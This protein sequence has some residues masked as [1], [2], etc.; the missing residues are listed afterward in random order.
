M[1]AAVKETDQAKLKITHTAMDFTLWGGSKLAYLRQQE[2][3]LTV[4]L[5]VA[6]KMF[7][8]HRI[9]FDYPKQPVFFDD[10]LIS[11]RPP[12]S[13]RLEFKEQMLAQLLP[14]FKTHVI[15]E[16]TQTVKQERRE[17]KRREE[18]RREEKRR[19]EKRKRREEKRAER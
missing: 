6:R 18:K 12:E 16:A 15:E 7:E 17:E 10:Q 1:F 8:E 5:S 11:F 13:S 3:F 2:H 14:G 9:D 19:K 4:G